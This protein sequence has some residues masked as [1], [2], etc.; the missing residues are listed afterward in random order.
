MMV[1]VAALSLGACADTK[2]ADLTSEQAN[3]PQL[4]LGRQVFQDNCARCH[5]GNGQGGAGPKL[6]DGRVVEHFPDPA[7]EEQVIRNG[8]GAM[9]AWDKKLTD[10]QIAAVLRYTREAL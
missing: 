4:V 8:R 5:G 9:P 10:E 7:Q 3:D 2:T 1:G 6:S